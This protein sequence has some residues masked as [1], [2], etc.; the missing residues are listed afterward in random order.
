[1]RDKIVSRL[2]KRRTLLNQEKILK[3][4]EKI[5]LNKNPEFFL[6]S[7]YDRDIFTFDLN[8][9]EVELILLKNSLKRTMKYRLKLKIKILSNLFYKFI[10]SS[11]KISKRLIFSLL[12]SFFI[13]ILFIINSLLNVFPSRNKKLKEFQKIKKLN[14]FGI[15]YLIQ[16]GVDSDKYYYK[17]IRENRKNKSLVL[18]FYPWRSIFL[19]LLNSRKNDSYILQTRFFYIKNIIEL[20]NII[21][22]LF[23]YDFKLFL[24]AKFSI[25]LKIIDYWS[26]I[27]HLLFAV[28][29]II[30]LNN[31]TK[32]SKKINLINWGEN[33]L[34]TR[35]FIICNLINK[36]KTKESHVKLYTFIGYPFSNSYYPH[37]CPSKL[38]LKYDFWGEK[39][40]LQDDNSLHDMKSHLNRL[41]SDLTIEKARN[42]FIRYRKDLNIFSTNQD[43]IKKRKITFFTHATL[44]EF[45]ICI[46]KF[47]KY[48]GHNNNGL[49]NYTFWIRYH[50]SLSK[51]LINNLFISKYNKD[52][53]LKVKIKFIDPRKESIEESINKSENC[54]FGESG[55]INM[56]LEK[57]TKVFAISTSYRYD[58]PIQANTLKNKVNQLIYIY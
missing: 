13:I 9:V 22:R 42:I 14:I 35:S 3:I 1:M 55:Y 7:I 6:S 40:I 38:E 2:Y 21:S 12:D 34:Q 44:R 24:F 19:A 49:T 25:K 15:C 30:V 56:A 48:L 28:I 52:P 58:N 11:I 4:A 39:I 18:S 36:Y 41:G 10:K 8:K 27:N 32:S 53:L 33:Q 31:L 57:D 54:V 17:G 29:N 16:K 46:Q 23:L 37:Y 45:E 5:N 20:V 43:I 47:L 51:E 26:R 50:P